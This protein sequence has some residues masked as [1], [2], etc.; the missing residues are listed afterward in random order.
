MLLAWTS[1]GLLWVTNVTTLQSDWTGLFFRVRGT[2]F[3]TYSPL[4]TFFQ[5]FIV[6]FQSCCFHA[7]VFGKTL[8][9]EF[10]IS[11]SYT[12]WNLLSSGTN[13]VLWWRACYQ[14]LNYKKVC[15][16]DT[17]YTSLCVSYMHK[18]AMRMILNDML[19]TLQSTPFNLSARRI[20]SVGSSP[21]L[22]RFVA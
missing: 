8:V 14:K 7:L 13:T 10:P 4:L 2:S 21:N 11:Y 22:G 17:M 18:L 16:F 19:I 3:H 5:C 6:L 9:H 15:C 1:S 12:E 20:T